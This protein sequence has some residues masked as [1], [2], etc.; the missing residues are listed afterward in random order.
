MPVPVIARLSIR[1]LLRVRHCLGKAVVEL[2]GLVS[3]RQALVRLDHRIGLA[4]VDLILHFHVPMNNRLVA[5]GGA[6][7]PHEGRDPQGVPTTTPRSGPM[8]SAADH[9]HWLEVL[10]DSCQLGHEQNGSVREHT[11]R[12]TEVDVDPPAGYSVYR[13]SLPKKVSRWSPPLLRYRANSRGSAC[14]RS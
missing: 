3:R 11:S 8:N 6:P 14:S 7:P 9:H 1:V 10:R 13:R 12:E 2:R 4:A 5:H